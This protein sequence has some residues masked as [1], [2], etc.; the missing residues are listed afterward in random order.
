MVPYEDVG[1]RSVRCGG[2]QRQGLNGRRILPPTTV[3]SAYLSSAHVDD[4]F[5]NPRAGPPG[6]VPGMIG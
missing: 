5:R 4:N 2:N 6:R 3:Q 1:E